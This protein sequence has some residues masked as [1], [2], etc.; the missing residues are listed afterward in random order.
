MPR[1]AAS[2]LL[3]G[4]TVKVPCYPRHPVQIL[5]HPSNP[6]H[7]YTAFEL[8]LEKIRGV[9]VWIWLREEGCFK[10]AAIPSA[11]PIFSGNFP[12]SHRFSTFLHCRKLKRTGSAL[13]RQLGSTAPTD[14]T[15]RSLAA[16]C[17][18]QIISKRRAD[19]F[20]ATG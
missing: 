5:P 17:S 2:V 9:W 6:L 10:L 12:L 14:L 1:Y 15:A 20:H 8:V 3:Q 19:D 7:L 16:E 11:A 4:W 13:T 18:G